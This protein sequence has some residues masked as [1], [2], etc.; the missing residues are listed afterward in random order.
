MV[1]TVIA[2]VIVAA[3]VAVAAVR[4]VRTLRGKGGCGCGCD[5]CP[6]S[7]KRECHCHDAEHKLPDIKL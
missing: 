6:K 7:G 3:A 2:L 5:H 1:Q 4:L